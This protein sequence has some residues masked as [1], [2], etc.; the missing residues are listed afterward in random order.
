VCLTFDWDPR[1][2]AINVVKHRL[3]FEKATEVFSDPLA[4]IFADEWHP[5]GERREIIIG[6]IHDRKLILVVYTEP[7][8]GCIRMIS[9]RPAT[10]KEQRDYEQHI[11]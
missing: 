8:E 10:P 3:T 9:A 1:K 6:H 11:G 2:A 4:K 7:S 5:E